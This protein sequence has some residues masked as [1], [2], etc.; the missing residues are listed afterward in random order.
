VE[1]PVPSQFRFE[2]D[3]SYAGWF[4]EA[5]KPWGKDRIRLWSFLPDTFEAYARFPN[6]LEH[7]MEGG[8]QDHRLQELARV[9]APFTSRP[10]RCWLA[11]WVGWGS[12][13]PG[14]SSALTD[15]PPPRRGLWRRRRARRDVQRLALETHQKLS[16]LPQL[17]TEHRK[18]FLFTARLSDVASFAIGPFTQTPSIWWP[19]DRA[20]CVAT[21]VDGY[22][23]YVGGSRACIE[24]VLASELLRAGPITPDTPISV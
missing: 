7:E 19:D 2:S 18:Y 5:L 12:W 13:G 20:W 22:D 1:L 14:S 3:V 4:A 21:E 24:A 9:L 15:D 16:A 17:R 11:S 6:H 23:S 10:E 8:V